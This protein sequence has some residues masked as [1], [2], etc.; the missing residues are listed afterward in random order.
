MKKLF[1]ILSLLSLLIPFFEVAKANEYQF[2]TSTTS[3]NTVT[4]YGVTSNGTST[5]LNSYS[6]S[7]VGIHADIEDGIYDEYNGKVYFSTYEKNASNANSSEYLLEYDLKNN[8]IT[9]LSNAPTQDMILYPKGI[10][11][12]IRTDASTGITSIGKNSLKMKETAN[13]QQL[14]GTNAD[15]KVVPINITNGSKLLINGRD[16]EQ[17]INNIG[18]LSAALTGLPTVP[19]ETT[20]ACGLGS[21]THGGD[22]AFSGGCASKINEK[23][24]VNYAA[25]MTMPG[26]DYAGDFEDTFSAR[27]GFVWKLGKAIKPT[28]ISMKEKENF[29]NKIES[30]EEK[31]KQ[32]LSRLERLEKIALKEIK[33]KDLAIY[34]LK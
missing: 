21:G 33:S 19:T 25:S 2:L 12:L 31:N 14:W 8:S 6:G 10:N 29:K 11:E 5:T 1:S 18:A 15:G 23:L 3:G 7:D 27:A 28:Q 26:Q 16:V 13:E 22:F 4:F 17:S 9:K 32:L 24:S 20:L 34:K 30:L